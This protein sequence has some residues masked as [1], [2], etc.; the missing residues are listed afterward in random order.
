MLWSCGNSP[1]LPIP[2]EPTKCSSGLL[3]S[4][5]RTGR[6]LY[7]DLFAYKSGHKQDNSF[8]QGSL[9][10]CVRDGIIFTRE[11]QK[12]VITRFVRNS[13]CFASGLQLLLPNQ[14]LPAISPPFNFI[15]VDTNIPFITYCN[16]SFVQDFLESIKFF[17][18]FTPTC[19]ET[20]ETS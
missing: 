18:I 17:H 5:S 13:S 12:Q 16:V 3:K 7:V 8:R 11:H 4:G 19:K 9:Y 14:L 15:N 6:N 10:L 1:V 20:Y 2:S